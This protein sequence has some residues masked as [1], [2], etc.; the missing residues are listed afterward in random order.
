MDE[1]FRALQDKATAL[2]DPKTAWSFVLSSCSGSWKRSASAS[3]PGHNDPIQNLLR[4]G[5]RPASGNDFEQSSVEI[6]ERQERISAHIFIRLIRS[7]PHQGAPVLW[8]SPATRRWA[9][10]VRS[11]RWL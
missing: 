11:I 3:A 7:N 6:E 9:D 1:I 4:A 2:A 10:S 8:P 5:A